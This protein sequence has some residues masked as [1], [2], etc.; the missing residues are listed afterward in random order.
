MLAIHVHDTE[1]PDGLPPFSFI[2]YETNLFAVRRDL[3]VMLV[4]LGSLREVDGLGPVRIH[5]K[6]LPVVIDVAFVGDFEARKPGVVH[7]TGSWRQRLS[8]GD[9][10]NR[11]QRNDY[12]FANYIRFQHRPRLIASL[13]LA[14]PKPESQQLTSAQRSL[15]RAPLEVAPKNGS[16]LV[17]IRATA[18]FN[19]SFLRFLHIWA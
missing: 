19:G 8:P 17:S 4:R 15:S 11:N 1:A 18:V 13:V 5:D 7:G 12:L 16:A 9:D 14:S 2:H 3:R 6:N 10:A